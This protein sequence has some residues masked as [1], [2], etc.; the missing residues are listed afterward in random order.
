MEPGTPRVVIVLKAKSECTADE[1]TAAVRKT[2]NLRI[3]PLDD[4]LDLDPD[5][6]SLDVSVE[7]E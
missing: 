7:F 3:T 6:E 4:V 5:P 1:I 2:I